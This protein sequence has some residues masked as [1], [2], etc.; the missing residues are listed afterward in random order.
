M[1]RVCVVTR[2]VIVG[3]V[4]ACGVVFV[5]LGGAN[6]HGVCVL[7][8]CGVWGLLQAC[9]MNPCTIGGWCVFGWWFVC[10]FVGGATSHWLLCL[11]LF[12]VHAHNTT[13]QHP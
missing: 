5:E 12:D 3:M 4:E 1:W 2:G 11:L 6:R 10:G 7:W 9:V 8:A 13:L